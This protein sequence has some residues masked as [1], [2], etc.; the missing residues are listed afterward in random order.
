MYFTSLRP[1]SRSGHA[2]PRSIK[3]SI[4]VWTMQTK[5]LSNRKIIGEL[6]RTLVLLGADDGLLGT[7]GSWG[8]SLPDK[9]VLAGLRGW[10][11]AT[12]KE[13]T[14]RIKHCE[15]TFHRLADTRNY[16]PPAIN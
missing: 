1:D 12:L 14:A 13:T 16:R 10:N 15:M 8:D 4:G 7:V 11:Q 5:S 2:A 6:Y 3:S 9:D